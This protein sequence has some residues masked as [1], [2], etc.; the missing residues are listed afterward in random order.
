MAAVILSNLK[1]D[2]SIVG[3]LGGSSQVL[4]NVDF[5]D[6]V[7][8]SRQERPLCLLIHGDSSFS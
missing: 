6:L 4:A 5:R 2:F 3:V 8:L 7:S 1:E